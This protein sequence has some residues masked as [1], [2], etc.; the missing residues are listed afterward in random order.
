V[1][2]V[3][4]PRSTHSADERRLQ[5]ETALKLYQMLDSLTF[6]VDATV[7]L[8]DQARQRPAALPASDTLRKRLETLADSLESLRR[9]LV[10]YKESGAF[11]GEIRLREKML[12]LYGAV[13]GYEG[14][15]T[16]TQLDEMVVLQNQ[17]ARARTQLDSFVSQDVP[18]LNALLAQKKLE[19]LKPLTE[20]EWRKK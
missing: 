8:R 12:E 9:T 19:P 13:N 6:V 17:L 11:T 14:R 1:Q 4:D 2:L 18:P 3:A 20:E 5:R 16:Q 7:A 15:P 10:A